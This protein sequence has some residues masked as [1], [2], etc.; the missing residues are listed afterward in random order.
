ML[1]KLKKLCLSLLV[2]GTLSSPSLAGSMPSFQTV[3]TNQPFA[4]YVENLKKAISANKMGLVSHACAHCGA[5]KIG[6][7]IA[8]NQVLMVYHPRFAVRML[9]ASIPAGIEAPLRLYVTEEKDG[10]A[11]LTYRLASDVFKP[12]G[13]AELDK[14]AL[15]LDDILAKIAK[16][17]L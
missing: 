9:K 10:T 1:N 5:K 8:G 17:S 11:K 14:M 2:V 6:V 7:E 16:D 15:E 12:Y 4:A 3:E 13:S